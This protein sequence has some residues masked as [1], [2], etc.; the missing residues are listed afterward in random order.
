MTGATN[1]K[2]SSD[3]DSKWRLPPVDGEVQR[4]W[5]IQPSL[6]VCDLGCDPGLGGDHLVQKVSDSGSGLS[7]SVKPCLGPKAQVQSISQ[8]TSSQTDWLPA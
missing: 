2:K 1:C 6:P 5:E 3:A 4:M 7:A 8:W